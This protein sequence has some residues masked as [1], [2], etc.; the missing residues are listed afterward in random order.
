MIH[1]TEGSK[2]SHEPTKK[3]LQGGTTKWN[4]K[5]L[6]KGA[7]SDAFTTMVTPF[8]KIK[9]GTLEPWATLSSAQ[10]QE[11]IDNVYGPEHFT[12]EEDDVWCG[13]VSIGDSYSILILLSRSFG[14]LPIAFKIGAMHL[15][16]QPPMLFGH[17]SMILKTL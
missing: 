1:I 2:P 15:P 12:V 16:P 8:V 7:D 5:H 11:I 10:I 9:A 4:L 17:T 3:E 13:L 6:P 14:R